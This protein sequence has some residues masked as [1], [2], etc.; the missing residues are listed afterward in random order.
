MK[1]VTLKLPLNLAKGRWL[2][3][4]ANNLSTGRLVNRSAEIDALSDRLMHIF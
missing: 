1:E 4:L 3:Y 2:D